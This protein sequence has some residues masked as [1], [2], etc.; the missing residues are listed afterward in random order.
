MVDFNNQEGLTFWLAPNQWSAL[1]YDEFASSALGEE[2]AGGSP[3]PACGGPSGRRRLAQGGAPATVDWK[4]ENKVSP[5]KKQGTKVCRQGLPRMLAGA[6]S[7]LCCVVSEHL[8]AADAYSYL[9]TPAC[10]P[11]AP[12]CSA[13]AAGRMPPPPRWRASC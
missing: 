2:G 12:A 4:A 3:G 13:A 10:P 9:P 5:V 6:S 1:T 7:M 8:A 11:A